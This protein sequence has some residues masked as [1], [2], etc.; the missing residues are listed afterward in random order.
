MAAA[1][2]SPSGK[3]PLANMADILTCPVNFKPFYD[4]VT[5]FPCAHKVNKEVALQLFGKTMENFCIRTEH[6][7]P[8][9]RTVVIGYSPDHAV[10]DLAHSFFD[11][12]SPSAR[13]EKSLALPQEL[14]YP[15]R[16]GVFFHQSGDWQPFDCGK[17][18]LNRMLE[19][20]SKTPDSLINQFS[21]L[22]YKDGSVALD[23]NIPLIARY[24][25]RPQ[26]IV[27]KVIVS[28]FRSHELD[29]TSLFRGFIKATT[30]KQVR[31][32]FSIL[33]TNNDIP[34]PHLQQIGAIIAGLPE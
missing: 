4:A 2:A 30:P 10:R 31:T 8:V 18:D 11:H 22:G 7:C 3:D 12:R 21:L 19:F 20:S 25:N 26:H 29:Y 9:C 24:S 1:A 15:G 6:P 14:P 34:E 28:Y 16:R 32:L 27:R 5:L 33:A 13:P 23:I 17:S